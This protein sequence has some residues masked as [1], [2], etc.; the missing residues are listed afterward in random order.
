MTPVATSTLEDWAPATSGAGAAVITGKVYSLSS[1][2]GVD[3]GYITKKIPARPGET[4]TIR[5]LARRI[6]GVDGTSGSLGIDYPASGSLKNRVEVNSAS[7]E[8]YSVSY[9]VPHTAVDT[10]YVQLVIGTWTSLGGEIEVTELEILVSGGASPFARM[11]AASLITISDGVP[12]QNASFVNTG[13]KAISYSAG[14]KKLY[15][16]IP[17]VVSPHNSAPV[18]FAELT[19]N[20]NLQ[21][22]ARAGEFN[23]TTGLFTVFF[24]DTTT[25]LAVDITPLGTMYLNV[26][27]IG[28]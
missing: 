28:I 14:T 21:L 25:G 13:I 12:A 11:P 7:W 3:E 26:L 6:S 16:T 20:T 22:Q 4:V 9:T 18:I 24:I 19:N 23:R 15:V 17:P 8:K 5:A 1:T 2:V 27:A 10:D